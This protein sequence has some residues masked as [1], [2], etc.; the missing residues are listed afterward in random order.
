MLIYVECCVG[1]RKKTR[2]LLLKSACSFYQQKL[3]VHMIWWLMMITSI[4]DFFVYWSI[5][6]YI[7]IYIY[8]YISI[9]NMIIITVM[10]I[11]LIIATIYI[12]YISIY[13]YIYIYHCSR[14][15]LAS[16]PRHPFHG[17]SARRRWSLV[18]T[19]PSL[20]VILR[21]SIWDLQKDVGWVIT[22]LNNSEY[23]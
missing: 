18:A 16:K 17:T 20:K 10:F 5:Y 14:S 22:I 4:S 13:I 1:W 21:G 15:V 2:L 6:V 11:T 19:P 8:M 12:Y 3:A 23:D 7:H 9:I